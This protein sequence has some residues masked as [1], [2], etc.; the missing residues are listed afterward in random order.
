MRWKER[1]NFL[2]ER[3]T[4]DKNEISLEHRIFNLQCGLL[5]L[6]MVI[7]VTMNTVLSLGAVLIAITVFSMFVIGSMYYIS[8]VKKKTD[9]VFWPY[10]IYMILVQSCAWFVNGGAQSSNVITLMSE[11]VIFSIIARKDRRI[12]LGFL[13]MLNFT[14]LY[15]VE[16]YYPNL[17]VPYTN[18]LSQ[19]SDCYIS[20][21]Y[22]FVGLFSVI[23][24]IMDN[25]NNVIQLVEQE[26]QQLV[27]LTQR[28]T[29]TGTYNRS[30]MEAALDVAD[31]ER[32]MNGRE[33]CLIVIDIDHF[34]HIN[35][36][37]GHMGGDIVLIDFADKIGSNIG[38]L[39][40]LGR[41]G[42]EEFLILCYK[43]DTLSVVERAEHLRRIVEEN[44]VDYEG[45]EIRCTAS[46]GVSCSDDS[47]RNGRE[48]WKSA[49][50]A[51]YVAKNNG[52]NRVE[53][54]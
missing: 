19:F 1:V 20:F 25:Y 52:R 18:R 39:D 26:K 24:I 29:L 38:P 23:A 7:I 13:F 15:G 37:F 3:L 9:L 8:R 11:G 51:L 22:C 28:D 21:V 46:F 2:V 50:K 16:Y 27:I 10:V 14:V 31:E 54:F 17:I 12:L 5:V 6:I 42:G 40:L 35:D 32:K 44:A 47:H 34:K 53:V 4:G 45:Q 41:V 30:F 36:R 43:T 48:L 49:D 33:Y